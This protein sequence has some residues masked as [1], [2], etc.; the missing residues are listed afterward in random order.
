MRPDRRRA[1][2]Q[3]FFASERE[4]ASEIAVEGPFVGKPDSLLAACQTPVGVRG[5]WLERRGEFLPTSNELSS[6]G[7]KLR[8][9]NVECRKN[10]G[11]R[12][13]TRLAKKRRSLSQKALYRLASLQATPVGANKGVVEKIP[14][15]LWSSL[16]EGEVVRGEHSDPK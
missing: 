14:T 12:V 13:S 15:V 4:R 9:P 11:R 8:V 16:D 7:S 5:E 2:A 6:C 1:A 10:V 3:V